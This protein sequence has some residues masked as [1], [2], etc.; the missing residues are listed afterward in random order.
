MHLHDEYEDTPYKWY[1]PDEVDEYIVVVNLPE[2]WEEVHNYIINDNE[3]DGFIQYIET[4]R[5]AARDKAIF[6]LGLRAGM[7][8]GSIA[9]LTLNDILDNSGKLKEVITLR[10]EIT[11][12]GKTIRA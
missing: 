8:I 10:R 1:R 6:L 11:K 2:D 12:G 4:T 9:Q 7:R 5:Y 3:I